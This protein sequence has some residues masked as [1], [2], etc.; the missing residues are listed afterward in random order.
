VIQATQGDISMPVPAKPFDAN[1]EAT[2]CYELSKGSDPKAF[3]HELDLLRHNPAQYN[4]T[5]KA[6][7]TKEAARENTYAHTETGKLHELK[8]VRGPNGD[9]SS[10]YAQDV[11]KEND[12][13]KPALPKITLYDASAEAGQ[14]GAAK[15]AESAAAASARA[16]RERQDAARKESARIST[17]ANTLLTDLRNHDDKGFSTEYNKLSDTDK[18]AVGKQMQQLRVADGD[19]N[20]YLTSNPDGSIKTVERNGKLEYITPGEFLNET[21]EGKAR[22][23]ALKEYVANLSPEDRADF[24]AKLQA[25]QKKHDVI[26][27]QDDK[28]NIVVKGPNGKKIWDSKPENGFGKILRQG[29]VVIH[30]H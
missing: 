26:V 23:G 15:P 30:P 18:A 5:M 7:E 14:H 16:E 27:D 17:E 1:A 22:T 21:Q 13:E 10:I 11:S 8:I 3:Q 2:K 24:F 28:G 4:A 12:V 29:E 20:L 25:E 19:A 6:M 9:V